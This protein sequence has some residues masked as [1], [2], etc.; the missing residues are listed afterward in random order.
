[1][2]PHSA[3]NISHCDQESQEKRKV[4][5]CRRH[6][7]SDRRCVTAVTEFKPF[8]SVRRTRSLRNGIPD[9][10]LIQGKKPG[11]QPES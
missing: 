4:P 7:L 6:I 5:A 3:M 8:R 1:M 11:T 10:H 2:A 9:I